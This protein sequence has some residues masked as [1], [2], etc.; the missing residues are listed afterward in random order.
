M[1]FRKDLQY[2][3]FCFYG[4]LKNLRFFE[5][6][7]ILFLKYKGLSYTEIGR[8]Y[9]IR[10]ILT[11]LSEIPTGIIADTYGRKRALSLSFVIYIISFLLF[12]TGKGYWIF[13]FAF[14]L[15]GI[16]DAFRSGTHKGMIMKYLQIKSWQ[17]KK[18]DYYGHTRACSQ[19]GSAVS[20][21]I[22]GIIVFYSGNY[23]SIFLLSIVPYVINLFLILSYPSSLNQTGQ[24]QNKHL[25]SN[26]KNLWIAIKS[27]EVLSIIH[28]A[29]IFTAYQKA[30]KD[31]IQPVMKNVALILPFWIG[32]QNEKRSGILIGL[33]Y[34]ILYL[35]T[36]QASVWSNKISKIHKIGLKSLIFGFTAG[37]AGGYF[38]HI[39]WW[40]TSLIAFAIIYIV[41]SLRKPI[42]TA[43]L[44]DEVPNDILTSV[45]SAQSL[46][47]TLMTAV[48]SLTF[49]YLADISGLGQALFIISIFLAIISLF[50]GKRA[51]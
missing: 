43:Y 44:A 24:K 46:Y 36:A 8:L 18:I 26:I 6:F 22:A 12:Y 42:L 7:F 31:Y 4:F 25:L 20:S 15:Y 21:L 3:K 37:I 16:A 50:S 1:S 48:L 51:G 14:V 13:F 11:N 5:A 41:E 9:A 45:L 10:E 19:R 27:P 23:Q 33:M 2:Y 17:D 35:L 40:I 32:L 39:H 38:F 47:R 49:G 30:V 34:F 28:S 29:A